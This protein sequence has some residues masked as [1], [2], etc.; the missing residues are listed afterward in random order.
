VGITSIPERVA[1]IAA[2]LNS[3]LRAGGE[4]TR[5][6]LRAALGDRISLTPDA[7]G[8]FLWAEYSLGLLPPFPGAQGKADLVVR[9]L[10]QEL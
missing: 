4:K 7:S 2:R 10:A 5:E 9:G 1:A 6:G 3:A 8:R